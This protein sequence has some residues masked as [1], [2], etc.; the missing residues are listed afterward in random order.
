M[1]RKFTL[2]V[3][4]IVAACSYASAQG[5]YYNGSEA[6]E[7]IPLRWT[8]GAN[9]TWDD[10]VTPGAPSGEQ[11][12]LSIN[13]YVGASFVN[14]TP[15]TTLD[16]YG[17]LGLI[18]YFD[19][20]V[21]A[22]ADD[23]N[24]QVRG[25]VNVSH[26][27]NER[28]RISSRNFI[29]YELEPDYSLGI[30]SARQVGEYL[31]WQ[32]DNALGYRWSERFG[33][34]T[35]F[36]LTGLE[37]DDVANADRFIWSLYTQG[38]YILTQ[39]T[40]LTADYRYSNSEGS[41]LASD[42]T[43]HFLL[44]GAEHRVSASTIVIARAGI[45]WRD[46]DQGRDST[47]PFL[48]MAFNSQVNEQLRVRS[49][50]R[51][52]VEDFDTVQQLTAG[53]PL[54]DFDERQALRIGISAEYAITPMLSLYGGVD[55][56]PSTFDGGRQVTPPGTGNRISGLDEDLINLYVGVSMKFTDSLH[57][58]LSYNFTDSSSDFASRSY[59]RNRVTV[60]VRAEF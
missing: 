20:P 35:G 21:A 51:Y 6:Q 37:Y 27:F 42:S 53:G 5:L 23:L 56:I 11:D 39:Q 30:S 36:Q 46:V 60:G 10:N 43:S 57:G 31:Y 34:Y 52:S 9:L 38:R 8:V 17:R 15:Q 45:Q 3:V 19:E 41:D 33:T 26:N 50:V 47:N 1:K 49:F 28:L 22:G 25:G 16:V 14:I 13:P 12:S 2:G 59:D 18:Y 44:G 24:T 48:E 58:T 4:S 7:S 40:V 54:Y 55:Y 29:S 32:T